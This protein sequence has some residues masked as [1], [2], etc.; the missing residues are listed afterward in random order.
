MRK[1]L[2]L[3]FILFLSIASVEAK[4]VKTECISA[5][6]ENSPSDYIYARVTK[7][8]SFYEGLTL[9]K[10]AIIE[11][12]ILNYTGAKRGKRN[13]YFT[14]EPVKITNGEDIIE[15]EEGTLNAKVQYYKKPDYKKAAIET[16]IGVGA[17]FVKGGKYVV[18]FSEGVIKPKEGES[19]IKSGFENL[20]E[21]SALSYMGR[22]KDLNLEE[23]STLIFKF[24]DL[25]VPKWKVW[26]R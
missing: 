21:N 14:V 23:G 15:I 18:Q 12:K 2:T 5:A 11:S 16:G 6:D 9:Q 13:G 4:N 7:D 25:D 20:Y 3:F 22:G 8:T 26:K 24:S 17:S 10:G 19:R 1:I